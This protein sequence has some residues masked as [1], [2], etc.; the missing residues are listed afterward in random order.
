[1]E[2][3]KMMQANWIGMMWQIDNMK[4]YD[5]ADEIAKARDYYKE[6]YHRHPGKAYI[7]VEHG[8]I[9]VE[10][11]NVHMSTNIGKQYVWIGVEDTNGD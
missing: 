6:K 7:N 2:R 11:V 9:V 1:M 10:G 8:Q 3:L 4:K 5:I